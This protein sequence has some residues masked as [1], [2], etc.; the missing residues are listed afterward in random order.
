MTIVNA[1]VRLHV[2][3]PRT[4]MGRDNKAFEYDGVHQFGLTAQQEEPAFPSMRLVEGFEPR[5]I[6]TAT[7]RGVERL[8]V[9][10]GQ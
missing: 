3:G 6:K 5:W 8:D 7:F 4:R 9:R 1:E 10:T 2:Q